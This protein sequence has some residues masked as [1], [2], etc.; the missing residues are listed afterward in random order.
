MTLS[1]EDL[2]QR[3]AA[4]LRLA[5]DGGASEAE[6][7]A[8]ASR[9]AAL[10]SKHGLTEEDVEFDEVPAVIATKGASP[11]DRL[12]KVVATCTNTAVI[13]DVRHR[14]T[15]VFVG[16]GPGP[17]IAAYLV[18]VLRRAVRFETE[19][20]RLTS[21]YRRRRTVATR[22]A[23]MH[24]FTLGLVTRISER[25]LALFAGTCSAEAGAEARHVLATR[26]P[27]AVTV[28]RP[29]KPLRFPA[30]ALSGYIAGS[31]PTLAHGTTGP[32]AVR[33]IGGA[34]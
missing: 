25:L 11:I 12:W 7:L 4:L 9:A 6:A 24:A 18:A 10:M 20:F 29:G 33:Q 26:F 19:A 15:L 28:T 17:E 2:K 21:E 34:A 31:R 22:R 16:A 30:A 27:G 1:P 13:L 3:I 8:A 23:A 14:P 32:S 5:R